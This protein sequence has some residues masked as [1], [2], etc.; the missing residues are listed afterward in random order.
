MPAVSLRMADGF[1]IHLN[2]DQAQR[3]KAAAEA[4]GVD[5]SVYALQ[6]LEQAMEDDW[7][8]DFRRIADYERTGESIGAAEWMQGLR[9]AVHAKFKA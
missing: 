2:E 4:S 6:I 3:L 5:P 7:A 8:E 9:E 1:D